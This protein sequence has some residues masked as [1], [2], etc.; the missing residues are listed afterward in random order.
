MIKAWAYRNPSPPAFLAA[1]GFAPLL[2]VVVGGLGLGGL[3]LLAF[4][5]LSPGSGPAAVVGLGTATL[6][7]AARSVLALVVEPRTRRDAILLL[8]REDLASQLGKDLLDEGRT[9]VFGWKGASDP[10]AAANADAHGNGNGQGNGGPPAMT[11]DPVQLKNLVRQESI[12]RI[13]VLE[14]DLEAREELASALLECRLLGVRVEDAVELY[15]RLHGKIWL[16][17]LDPGRLAFAEGFRITPSYR[18]LKRVVDMT[19]ALALLVLAAPVM[20]VVALAIKLESPGPVLFRQERV[21]Q[22]GKTFTLLKFRSMRQDAEKDGPAWASKNDSR[23]TRIGGFLR[24]SHLDEL[25]QV[26]NVFR[27]DLSFVGP[28]PER[29]CFVE[30][31]RQEIPFFDLRLYVKPGITGWA[32]VRYP[33]CD[34]VKDSYEKLQYDL[35]YAR[36]ASPLLD[37][38]ILARTAAV[39]VAGRGR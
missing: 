19:C 11:L 4:P 17:A 39:M 12:S 33:Y 31:L 1:A 32:Q 7:L 21:G 30:M 14:S 20:A 9:Q 36:K 26:I 27:G 25:P 22:F 6:L 16:E 5:D 37:L 18:F 34:S 24:K 2:A 10:P 8:G 28:R 29:P 23:V 35:Y 38:E 13:V 3:A 15:Q